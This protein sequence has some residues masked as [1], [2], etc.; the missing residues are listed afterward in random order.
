[1]TIE[2]D[3]KFYISLYG[4]KKY[5]SDKGNQKIAEAHRKKEEVVYL[6]NEDINL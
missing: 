5:Y 2:P 3:H 4:K 6:D 1:M